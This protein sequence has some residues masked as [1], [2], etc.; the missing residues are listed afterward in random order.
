MPNDTQV[1]SAADAIA[2][3]GALAQLMQNPGYVPT[4]EMITAVARMITVIAEGQPVE[5]RVKGWERWERF[6]AAVDKLTG[7]APKPE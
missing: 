4:V 1:A 7:Y 3:A 6:W 5:V 2:L